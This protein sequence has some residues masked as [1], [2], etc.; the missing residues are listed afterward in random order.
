MRVQ[1]GKKWQIKVTSTW[2][3]FFLGKINWLWHK[4][5]VGGYVFSKC[6]E[7]YFKNFF[8]INFPF[9]PLDKK[10]LSNLWFFFY[11]NKL[12]MLLCFN[13]LMKEGCL[14]V[15]F[16]FVCTYKIHCTRMLQ[17]SFLVSLE[18]SQWGGVHRLAFMAFGLAVQKFLNIEWFLH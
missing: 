10:F 6:V 18:S 12:I 8:W 1:V 5:C 17:I 15:L 2:H 11:S 9:F 7:F 16:C 3:H 14:F 4:E 13:L